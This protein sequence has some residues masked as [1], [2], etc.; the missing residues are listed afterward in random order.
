[1]EIDVRTVSSVRNE[2]TVNTT[3]SAVQALQG[4]AEKT[5]DT[6]YEVSSGEKTNSFQVDYNKINALKADYRKGYNAFRQMV[7]ELIQKQGS[8]SAGVLER[9]FGSGTNFEGV[10]D[11]GETL[12][13]LEVDEATR[14]KAATLISED[15]AW[16]VKQV[17]Q[18]ILNFAIAA[19]GNDPEKLE[20]M[21]E[22]FLKGFEQAEQVWGGKLPEISYKTKEAVLAGFDEMQGNK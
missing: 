10:K 1:M 19:A 4:V 16:G 8:A 11:L 17:S 2:N 20:K 21:K 9:I 22:A 14:A 6:A 3:R 18:N 12:A 5:D 15:G 7:S 13:S